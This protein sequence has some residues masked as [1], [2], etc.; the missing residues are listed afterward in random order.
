MNITIE[1]CCDV[2]NPYITVT[3]HVFGK[4]VEIEKL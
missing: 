1:N 3:N 4:F 2:F